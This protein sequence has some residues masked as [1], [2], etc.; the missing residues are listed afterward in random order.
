MTATLP[1]DLITRPAGARRARVTPPT[2]T[3]WIARGVLAGYQIGG[4]VFVSEAE[5]DSILANARIPVTAA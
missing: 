4:R 1:D 3:R 5:I 2:I